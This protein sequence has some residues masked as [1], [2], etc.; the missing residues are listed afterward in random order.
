MGY[1]IASD[2][3]YQVLQKRLR[4]GETRHPDTP[5]QS[6]AKGRWIGDDD[7]EPELVDPLA[8]YEG[9]KLRHGR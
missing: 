7:T 9:L 6:A 8:V 4:E 1:L 5:P 2:L 3:S